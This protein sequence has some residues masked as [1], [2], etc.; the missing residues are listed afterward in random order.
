MPKISNSTDTIPRN[1]ALVNVLMKPYTGTV[2]TKAQ[3]SYRSRVA[4]LGT[5]AELHQEP[6]RY[7]LRTLRRLV[8][9][10]Q[11]DLLCAEIHPDDWQ[12]GDASKMSPEY[13]DALLPLSRRTDIIIVPVSGSQEW[14]LIIPKG[15]RLLGLRSL[16]LSV[17]NGQLRV[18]QR[19]ANG[20]R[21]INS[22]LFGWLCDGM[23]TLTAWVCGAESRR[24][25][26]KA[27]QALMDNIISAVRRDPGRRVLVTV[28]CRRRH[29][30]ERSLRLEPEVEHVNYLEL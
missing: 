19:L 28:D 4:V 7:N 1:L 8:K 6:I 25:W 29:R 11:P 30:L 5:L 24:A 21:A 23:C 12:N 13:R 2:S 9:D 10:I 14:E 20:P 27:N 16:I 3:S 17:L 15:G 18:M 22:G 26:D